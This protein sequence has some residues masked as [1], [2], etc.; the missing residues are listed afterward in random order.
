MPHVVEES[1]RTWIE[2]RGE[3]EARRKRRGARD[4]TDCHEPI[5]HRLPHHLERVAAKLRKLVE[6]QHAVMREAHFTRSRRSSAADETR[7]RDRVMRRAERAAH[8]QPASGR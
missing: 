6:K 7:G 5:L 4:A 8:E 3:C 1:T 2:R